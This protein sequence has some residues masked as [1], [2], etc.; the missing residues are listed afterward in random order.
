[1]IS[2][3][4]T[5]LGALARISRLSRPRRRRLASPESWEPGMR[6]WFAATLADV[7]RWWRR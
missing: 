7:A 2:R 1:M 4:P 3:R 6:E 5:T